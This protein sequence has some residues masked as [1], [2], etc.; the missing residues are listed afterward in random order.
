MKAH[1]LAK[2]LLAGPNK[3]VGVNY[4]GEFNAEAKEPFEIELEGQELVLLDIGKEL[5]PLV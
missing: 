3:T 1:D 4:N 5:P 2:L